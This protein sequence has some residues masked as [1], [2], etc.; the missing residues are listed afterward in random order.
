MTLFDQT[1]TYLETIDSDL[2]WVNNQFEYAA[3]QT[4]IKL[5][6]KGEARRI[7]A[8]VAKLPGVGPLQTVMA[9]TDTY[10]RFWQCEACWKRGH[11]HEKD[12]FGGCPG[13]RIHRED[14]CGDGCFAYGP[15]D[16]GQR[17]DDYRVSRASECMW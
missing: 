16:G 2:I 9:V 13:L 3:L 14:G 6:T 7:A 8:N 12:S 1:N 11:D 5:L 15:G 17:R 10:C 4:Q